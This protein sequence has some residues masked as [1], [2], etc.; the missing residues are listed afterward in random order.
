VSKK[1]DAF[2]VECG[3]QRQTSAPYSSKQNGVAKH[4]NRTTMECARSMI[5][6]QGFELEFWGEVVNIAIYIKN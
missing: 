6:T 4:A 3:I 2:L 5:L 1:F